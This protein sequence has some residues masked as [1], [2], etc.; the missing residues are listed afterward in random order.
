VKAF[1]AVLI[2]LFPFFT[3]TYLTVKTVFTQPD[4]VKRL[5]MALTLVFSALAIRLTVRLVSFSLAPVTETAFFFILALFITAALYV[6]AQG[7]AVLLIKLL[8]TLSLAFVLTSWLLALANLVSFPLPETK[9]SLEKQPP[10]QLQLHKSKKVKKVVVFK[11]EK[12][13]AAKKAVKKEPKKLKK[14]SIKVVADSQ[15]T[16]S[17]DIDLFHLLPRNLND[18]HGVELR[19]LTSNMV[20]LKLVSNKINNLTVLITVVGLHNASEAKAFFSKPVQAIYYKVAGQQLSLIAYQDTVT[21]WWQM[22]RFA[23]ELQASGS[24]YND[25][26]Q[27]I[28]SLAA[29]IIT[30]AENVPFQEQR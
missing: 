23:F 6:Q 8:L 14:L 22:S 24:N 16:A 11:N 2:W 19:R 7:R 15:K 5:S 29:A 18:W 20:L 28:L 10:L 30:N 1:L 3:L 17:P 4:V 27:A 21:A 26:K 12:Q 13:L 9:I 25:L